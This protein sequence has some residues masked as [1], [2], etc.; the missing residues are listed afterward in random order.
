MPF[1]AGERA[2]FIQTS[3]RRGTISMRRRDVV[4][5]EDEQDGM[6]KVQAGKK[7]GTIEARHLRRDGERNAIH[8]MA[9]AVRAANGFT[10]P[11]P[12]LTEPIE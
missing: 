6:V 12:G 3:G 1:K 11:V 5:L 10:N 4:V 8:D 9:E 7:T 2:H